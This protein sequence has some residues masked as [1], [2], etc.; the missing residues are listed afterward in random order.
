MWG[1]EYFI[2]YIIQVGYTVMQYILK[3][4][5]KQESTLSTNSVTDKLI[6]TVGAWQKPDDKFIYVH[7]SYWYASRPLYN[8]IKHASWDDV[9]LNDDMKK[10]LTE[11]M[12]K[13][14]D[15]KDIYKDLGVPWKRGC[16]FH[17]MCIPGSILLCAMRQGSKPVVGSWW[18]NLT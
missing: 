4:P 12:H 9:I 10:S 15:S 18:I 7:D 5:G 1:T 16:I 11:L 8:E 3:E 13:F 14:F 2:V 6:A 17:G